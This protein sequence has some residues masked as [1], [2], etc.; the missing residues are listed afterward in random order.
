MHST[1]AQTNGIAMVFL[2]LRAISTGGAHL[3]EM[4]VCASA[5]PQQLR[6]RDACLA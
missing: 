4:G 2:R 6:P 1:L 5:L 3:R